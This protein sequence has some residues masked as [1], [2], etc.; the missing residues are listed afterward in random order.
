M[1]NKTS[2][3]D[4]KGQQRFSE[5]IDSFIENGYT[6]E[7]EEVKPM[8]WH[9]IQQEVEIQ[10][11]EQL[12]QEKEQYKKEI[13]E[14]IQHRYERDKKAG[15]GV[16][17]KPQRQILGETRATKQARHNGFLSGLLTA[18]EDI[19]QYKSKQEEE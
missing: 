15:A 17:T 8:L 9:F 6:L 7:D 14:T 3:E 16:I 18:I 5:L 1:K 10:A 2:I 11:N 4:I 12:Q 19:E 13:I